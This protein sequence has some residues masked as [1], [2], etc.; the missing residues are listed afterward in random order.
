MMD[1]RDKILDAARGEFARFGIEGARVDR[2]ARKARVNKAMIYYHFRS[3]DKLYQAVIES[4]MERVGDFLEKTLSGE[5]DIESF[6]TKL[7]TFYSMMG[8]GQESFVPLILREIAGGSDRIKAA[9]TKII[10][11]RGLIAK[12]KKMVDDGIKAGLYRHIDLKQAMVSFWGMNLFYILLSPVVNSV[13]EIDDA[14]A[15]RKKRPKEVVDLFLNG[16]KVR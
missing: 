12:L 15:F 14:E 11:E 4:H 1:S 10:A 7:A 8:V 2:I 6:L 13:W 16:L 3:K 9:L 5:K